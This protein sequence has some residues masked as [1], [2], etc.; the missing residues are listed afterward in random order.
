VG[1]A[2]FQL[3]GDL[4]DFV[5]R[6]GGARTEPVIA[7][8]RFEGR[9]ALKDVLEAVGVPHPEVD[10]VL[11]DGVSATLDDPLR[12][13]ALVDVF[14]AGTG[15]AG[16]PRLLPAPQR[17]PR[18]VLDGHLG[19]LASLLRALGFDT[20]WQ[21]DWADEALAETSAREDRVLLTRDVGLLKRRRVRRGAF[22]RSTQH[23]AQAREVVARFGLGSLARPFTR[24]LR[25]NGPLRK[26][27]EAEASRAPPRVRERHQRYLSCDG[28]G[29]LYWPGTHHD[30]LKGALAEVLAP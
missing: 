21:R 2:R 1:L 9:P 8:Q 23:R 4:G 26:A 29:G 18:F 22:V 24:C 6:P 30:R 11:V 10:L 15:P 7:A 3:H 27:T 25:C 20:L 14:P 28:C 19:R 16:H 13:G 12:D 17:S 5:R